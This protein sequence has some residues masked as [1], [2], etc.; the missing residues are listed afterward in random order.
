MSL[1]RDRGDEA[2]PAAVALV[3]AVACLLPHQLERMLGPSGL[4]YCYARSTH[5]DA[6][7]PLLQEAEPAE[8][9][10][11]PVRAVSPHDAALV[12][13]AGPVA[14]LG[15]EQARSALFQSMYDLA[16]RAR[17]LGAHDVARVRRIVRAACERVAREDAAC[18]DVRARVCLVATLVQRVFDEC[19]RVPVPVPASVLE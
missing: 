17:K 11:S 1:G 8:R 16:Q 19:D 5:H 18:E 7:V 9:S 10:P 2:A 13:A 15:E 4:G 3:H 14:A 6:L 12:D